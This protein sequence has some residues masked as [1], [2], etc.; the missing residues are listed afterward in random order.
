M[1]MRKASQNQ[2]RCRVER[3]TSTYVGSLTDLIFPVQDP[4][5]PPPEWG[6]LQVVQSACDAPWNTPTHVGNASVPVGVKSIEWTTP[7]YMGKN[8]ILFRRS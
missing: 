7:T 5:L 8:R 4:G 6:K 3:M 1:Y 2:N